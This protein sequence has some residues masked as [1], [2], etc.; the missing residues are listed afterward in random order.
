MEEEKTYFEK[1]I[2]KWVIRFKRDNVYRDRE[3]GK[4][5]YRK[6]FQIRKEWY[7]KDYVSEDWL[8][9]Y[10][11]WNHPTFVYD[12][13]EYEDN[14]HN[15][16][17]SLGWGLLYIYFPWRNSHANEE[18][19]NNERPKW[20][21][22]CYGEGK[23]LFT[24]IWLCYGKNGKARHKV[25]YMPWEYVFYRHSIYL[26]DGTWWTMLDKERK[27]ACKAGIDTWKDK[28]YNLRDDDESIKREKHQFAYTTKYGDHQETTATCFIE[29]REWRQRWLKWT[30]LFNHVRPEVSISFADE[31]GSERGSWKG[32]VMGVGA[33]MTF[34][35][36]DKADM[37]SA[38]RRYEE[39]VNRTNS[40]DR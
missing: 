8:N 39:K 16:R 38:L 25:L 11:G 27:K 18:D 36:R 26:K 31:M 32:G 23:G 21:F 40:Y 13:I 28:R 19:V 33:P 34:E 1:R 2:G 5:H 22:Y 3:T 14:R 10:T 35:E 20:G 37:L 17:C 9:F 24:S 30:K 4:V 6:L 29:E 15:L 7:G 12:T